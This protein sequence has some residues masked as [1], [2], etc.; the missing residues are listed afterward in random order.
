MPAGSVAPQVTQPID[1]YPTFLQLAGVSRNPA[2]DGR[3]LVPLLR[4]RRPRRWGTLA[5]V[6]QWINEGAA[7]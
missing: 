6:E 1:L 4:A 2:V 5:L 7:P 3:S